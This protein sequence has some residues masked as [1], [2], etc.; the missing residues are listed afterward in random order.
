MKHKSKE[1]FKFATPETK[2][3]K[4]LNR[5]QIEAFQVFHFRSVLFE[6]CYKRHHEVSVQN[7]SDTDI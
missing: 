3:L 7:H 1:H 2:S 5:V 6:T 4:S